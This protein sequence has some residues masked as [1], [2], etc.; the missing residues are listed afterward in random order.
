MTA[1]FAEGRESRRTWCLEDIIQCPACGG[2]LLFQA[3]VRRCAACGTH[4]PD[5]GGVPLMIPGAPP[6]SVIPAGSDVSTHPYSPNAIQLIQEFEKGLVLDLG[7]GGKSAH[8][9]NVVQL[10]IFRFPQTDVIGM[11]EALP[12]KDGVFDA[13]ISQAVFEHL[14][15]PEIAAREIYRVCKPGARIKIDTA[16]LQPLHGYP[17]HYFNATLSGLKHWFRDFDIQWEGVETY[18]HPRYTLDWVLRAYL[19][20]MSGDDADIFGKATVTEMIDCISGTGA[21]ANPALMHCLSNLTFEKQME[22]ASG[23]S[24]LAH[25]AR[26]PSSSL[27]SRPVADVNGVLSDAKTSRLESRVA[28][29]EKVLKEKNALLVIKNETIDVLNNEFLLVSPNWWDIT[30]RRVLV[31]LGRLVLRGGRHGNP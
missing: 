30:L 18:Q 1:G 25:R 15:H 22:L 28:E 7:A 17:D 31:K 29:L 13:V 19:A 8:Y 21:Q 26:T 12:F 20:G 24:I 14:R 6:E 5:V 23:V 16:F 4:Y 11:A 9:P 2:T 3:G 10:D 27:V